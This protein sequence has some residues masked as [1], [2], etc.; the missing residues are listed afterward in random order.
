MSDLFKYLTKK[1]TTTK[2]RGRRQQASKASL[3]IMQRLRS[4]HTVGTISRASGRLLRR[5]IFKDFQSGRGIGVGAGRDV[6]A[7]RFDLI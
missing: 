2:I 1:T 3:K 4:G 7:E 5:M 6:C